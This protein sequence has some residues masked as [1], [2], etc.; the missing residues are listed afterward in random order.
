MK[1]VRQSQKT[2]IQAGRLSRIDLENQKYTRVRSTNFGENKGMSVTI[3]DEVLD[4]NNLNKAYLRV[5]S[6]RGAAGIDEMTVDELFQYLRENKEE[7]TTSL[8]EGSYKPLPVKRVEIPKLNG[9]TRKLGIPTVI[10]RMVQ[11]A[12]AQVL[13]PI[14]EEIFSENSFGFRPNRGAQDAIDKVISYYN[15]GYKR[16]VDLDL[17]SYF[18]NVNH[19][20]MIKYL[21]QYIDDEWTLKLIRKFL[22]S[23][24]LDNG[25]FVKSEKGTPQGG[26]LSPLLANIYLNKL[27]KELTKR[28]HRFVRYADDCNIYV[29]SQRAGERVMRSITKFLEKQLKVKVNTDK[30]RVGSPIKL[31]FLGFSLGV[32]NKGGYARPS[33]ESQK[34]VRQA[35]KMTTKRNR[36]ISLN[37]MF[38]EIYQK[39]RGWLQYYSIGRMT[40]FIR[41]LDQWLRSRIRQYIW[42]QWKK[43]KT[44]FVNLKKLGLSQQDAYTFAMTRKGY[45]R[46][47]H[48]KTLTYTL[49]NRKL[50]QLGLINMSKVLQSIQSD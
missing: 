22:T 34:R 43:P 4:R 41:R 38:K 37:D 18:D 36:G 10:D 46:T 21:Q 5:K 11:Q 44:R 7:L 14:F 17:K 49:T 48:S 25:L 35:L 50:E 9:G 12:V 26:P 20:L 39:M 2:E 42:K 27:D 19:D 16:V 28:G 32:D 15:Q 33:K 1:L 3:Q 8:R 30:T 40:T 24:I 45:W 6:N 23:G 31:K 13:T 29:K 47:A